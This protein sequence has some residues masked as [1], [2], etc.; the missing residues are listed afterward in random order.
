[1]PSF[2][3]P[4]GQIITTKTNKEFAQTY[5]FRESNVRSLACGWYR[6]FK[7]WCSMHPR[8]KKERERFMTV[9]VNTK[10][11]IRSILG[12]T[13][14]GFAKAH[15][16]SKQALCQLMNGHRV[17]YRHWMLENTL[18]ALGQTPAADF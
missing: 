10:T 12:Q 1:M 13:I 5:G 18:M 4:T 8:A 3:S 9:L 15:S 14:S 7:G 11:G 16:L 2:I 17:I 6:R